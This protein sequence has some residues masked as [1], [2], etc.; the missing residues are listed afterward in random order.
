[1]PS[2]APSSSP[3]ECAA[4]ISTDKRCF[5]KEESIQVTIESC[6]PSTYDWVAIRDTEYT[7]PLLIPFFAHETL[8]SRPCGNQ[9]CTEPVKSGNVTFDE[10]LAVGGD[11]QYQWPLHKG[12][13]KIYLI[14]SGLAYAESAEIQVDLKRC[15]ETRR[16]I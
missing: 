11:P 4:S 13:Y 6:H 5:G 15:K 3:T 14:H 9:T 1:V 16:K 10:T 2:A 8:W 7:S 12:K